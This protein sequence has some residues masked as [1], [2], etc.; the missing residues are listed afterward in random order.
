M[1]TDTYG[2]CVM[3]GNRLRG[4]FVGGAF[5]VVGL[6]FMA[7]ALLLLNDLLQHHVQVFSHYTQYRN[8]VL[9]LVLTSLAAVVSFTAGLYFLGRRTEE[10]GRTQ[11]EIHDTN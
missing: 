5:V 10:G 2:R 8:R 3:K 7:D 4:T 6:V 9:P 11:G 1:K